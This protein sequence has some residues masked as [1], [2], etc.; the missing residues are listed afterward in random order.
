MVISDEVARLILYC[1]HGED[2]SRTIDVQARTDLDTVAKALRA[3]AGWNGD[4]EQYRMEAGGKIFGNPR[5]RSLPHITRGRTTPVEGMLAT[6]RE[7]TFRNNLRSKTEHRVRLT[8]RHQR[9]WRASDYPVLVDLHGEMAVHGD[10]THWDTVSGLVD[11]P[12]NRSYLE[13]TSKSRTDQ[14][15]GLIDL[16]LEFVRRPRRGPIESHEPG[17]RRGWREK[18]VNPPPAHV[19]A[20]EDAEWRAATDARLNFITTGDGYIPQASA[21]D[22]RMKWRR[23]CLVEQVALRRDAWCTRE[24]CPGCREDR[25]FAILLRNSE[26]W[27]ARTGEGPMTARLSHTRM[28]AG[29]AAEDVAELLKLVNGAARKEDPSDKRKIAGWIAPPGASW[30][31]PME[32]HRYTPIL[33]QAAEGPGP[34]GWTQISPWPA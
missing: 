20:A 21:P 4:P 1:D 15:A 9:I 30:L 2:A 17:N 26:V 34:P 12:D 10:P 22:Q 19:L 14:L 7:F 3:A 25:Q 32:R 23:P 18:I 11:T 33:L 28:T 27:Y 31:D 24:A 13:S 5:G 29:R 16:E 8:A 6:E